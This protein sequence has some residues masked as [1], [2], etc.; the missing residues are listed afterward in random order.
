MYDFKRKLEKLNL[1]QKIM[2]IIMIITSILALIAMIT[3]GSRKGFYFNGGLL[4]PSQ[5]EDSIVYSGR[6]GNTQKITITVM[7]D[8]STVLYKRGEMEPDV[9]K[10]K[11]DQSFVPLD[12]RYSSK[13][14]GAEISYNDEVLF[15]GGYACG[16]GPGLYEEH[17]DTADEQTVIFYTSENEKYD[18]KIMAYFFGEFAQTKL[19]LDNVIKLVEGPDLQKKGFVSGIGKWFIGVV[20]CFIAFVLMMF[21][22]E[23]FQAKMHFYM[24]EQKYVEPSDWVINARKFEWLVLYGA[25][26]VFFAFAITCKY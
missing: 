10:I 2:L 18:A 23:I 21:E 17:F 25:A 3:N 26:I 8:H 7:N 22:E 6:D 4:F 19:T 15:T 24:R 20:I 14:T 1:F 12:N 5:K 16:Y 9:Y 11:Y 13:M